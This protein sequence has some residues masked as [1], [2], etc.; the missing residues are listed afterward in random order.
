MLELTIATIKERKIPKKHSS[1]EERDQNKIYICLA[2]NRDVK[3]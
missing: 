1:I 2:G 3:L